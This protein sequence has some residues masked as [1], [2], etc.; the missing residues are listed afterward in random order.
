MKSITK[1][2]LQYYID[3]KLVISSRHNELP[4][5]IYNYSEKVQFDNLWDNFLIHCRG[6]VIDDNGKFLNNPIPKFFNY[7]EQL[8][9]LEFQR[10]Y[11]DKLEFH[12]KFDGSLIMVFWLEEY[13][14]WIVCSRGSFHSE[15]AEWASLFIQNTELLRYELFKYKNCTL[16]FEA[17]YPK[18]RIV[19]NYKDEENLVLLAVRD[20]FTRNEYDLSKI[21]L[22]CLKSQILNVS[23]SSLEDLKTISANSIENEEGYVIKFENGNRVK[24]KFEEYVRLHKIMTNV[25]TKSVW[26]CLKNGTDIIKLLDGVPDEYFNKIKEYYNKLR[27]MKELLHSTFILSYEES[28]EKTSKMSDKEFAL[29]IIDN[30]KKHYF[31]A[32]R[33]GKDISQMLWKDLEPEYE[34]L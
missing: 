22:D 2:Q 34:K 4:I 7:S 14:Q 1:E 33:K 21:N 18:N 19:L 11:S 27:D 20:N 31:F 30:P 17:I 23:A 10:S 6:L 13:N 28:I 8:G 25:S 15:Q 12:T 16:C 26:E 29:T 24:V 9:S 5:A 32:L 3:N